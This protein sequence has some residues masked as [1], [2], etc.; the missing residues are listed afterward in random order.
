MSAQFDLYRRKIYVPSPLPLLNDGSGFAI[1]IDPWEMA[2]VHC[3][4]EE[5][6]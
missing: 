2:V 4:A 1:S 6:G 5:A 3:T